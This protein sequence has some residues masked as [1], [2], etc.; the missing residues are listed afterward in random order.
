MDNLNGVDD[1]GPWKDFNVSLF[2][3]IWTLMY[4]AL[5]YNVSTVKR[6]IRVWQYS[7]CFLV[8]FMSSDLNKSTWASAIISV[9]YSANFL[10]HVAE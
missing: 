2:Q 5:S 7:E 4:R 1:E 3:E 8:D 9:F 6:R 10:Y